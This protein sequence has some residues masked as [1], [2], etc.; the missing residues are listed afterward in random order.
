MCE[1]SGVAVCCLC[2]DQTRAQAASAV[3]VDGTRTRSAIG[4]SWRNALWYERF[5][6]S[7]LHESSAPVPRQAFA[8]RVDHLEKAG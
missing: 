6:A 4:P 1:K 2:W 5:F 8:R 7:P 3:E